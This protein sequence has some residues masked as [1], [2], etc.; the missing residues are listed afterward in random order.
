MDHEAG[1]IY[2]TPK[3]KTKMTPFVH[4]HRIQQR[5]KLM[6]DLSLLYFKELQHMH[7]KPKGGGGV[8]TEEKI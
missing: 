5:I 2:P 3:E 7:L 8:T 6:F 4:A 1:G